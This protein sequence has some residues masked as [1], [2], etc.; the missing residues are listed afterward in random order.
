M[1]MEAHLIK[2]HKKW[3]A[4]FG[5]TVKAFGTMREAVAWLEEQKE[6][7][8]ENVSNRQTAVNQGS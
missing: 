4:R 7:E 5:P 3:V 2:A 8:R 1:T 6:K